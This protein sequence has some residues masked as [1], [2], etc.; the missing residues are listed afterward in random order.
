MTTTERAGR[1]RSDLPGAARVARIVASLPAPSDAMVGTAGRIGALLGIATAGYGLLL[2]GVARLQH[3]ADAAATAARAPLVEAVEDARRSN[4]RLER[5]LL[6]ADGSLREVAAGYAA[7]TEEIGDHEAAL[8]ALGVLVGE[9]QGSVAAL[10]TRLALPGVS[11][12][13]VSVPPTTVATSG[14]SGG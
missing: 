4:D 1:G 3:D 14:A 6:A 2:A 12:R 11:V 7:T 8:D 9:I 13:G 5:A 10:P